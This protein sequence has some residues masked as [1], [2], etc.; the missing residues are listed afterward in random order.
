MCT[1]ALLW[2]RIQEMCRFAQVLLWDSDDCVGADLVSW[3]LTMLTEY[4]SGRMNE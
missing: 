4:S 1:K 3:S 2:T